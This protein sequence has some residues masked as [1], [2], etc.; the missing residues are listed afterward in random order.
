[1]KAS[2]D[3]DAYRMIMNRGNCMVFHAL[4]CFVDVVF[5]A[6][7]GVFPEEASYIGTLNPKRTVLTMKV[8]PGETASLSDYYCPTRKGM[9]FVGWTT[10][11]GG[12]V[13]Y[14]SGYSIDVYGK[15]T[16]YAVYVKTVTVKFNA[17]GGTFPDSAKYIDKDAELSADKKL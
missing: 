11:K 7:S 8:V 14:R 2:W 17:K 12:P 16:L 10:L 9:S 3:T 5:K 6:G 13:E 1:M 15:M 4:K